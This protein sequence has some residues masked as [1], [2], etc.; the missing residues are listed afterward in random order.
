MQNILITG[1][2]GYIGR[3]LTN[4]L[5]QDPEVHLHLFVRD[6][7]K[8]QDHLKG[9]VKIFQGT[10]FDMDSLEH[11]LQSIDT[12]Y[13]LIHS[14][15]AGKQFRPLDQESARN[16]REACL[17]ANV[18]RIIYLGG[19][20]NKDTASQHLLSRIETGEILSEKREEIQTIWFRAA[21]IIG[22]GSASFEII[23]HLVRKL[24]V[25]VTPSW[26]KTC[27]Q[28]IGVED[29]LDYLTQA[30]DLDYKDNLIVDIGAEPMSFKE[31]L[32]RASKAMG[33]KRVLIPLRLLT[34][35]LS[36]YWL[37]LMTPVRYKIA[38]E[39]VIGL[40]TETLVQNENARI[41]FPQIHPMPY[42]KALSLAV[43][44]TAHNKVAGCRCD[45]SARRP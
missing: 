18:R 11:A 32:I 28:P 24:P 38:R 31:M 8:I 2:T 35:R 41:F 16:F 5:L 9:K 25:M 22:S 17:S 29:V 7:R 4:R 3:R 15:G 37:I 12:A 45:S 40:R 43:S 34:P 6:P 13:Y 10:T 1:A 27:T 14:M 23:R 36:S 30:K 44:E 21:V 42:E 33:L 19:L 20:G 39:L 26:V